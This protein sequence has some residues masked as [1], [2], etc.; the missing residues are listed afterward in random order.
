MARSGCCGGGC[1]CVVMEGAH[2]TVEGSGAP[3]DPFIISADLDLEVVDNS[4]F[5]LTLVGDGSPA[6]PYQLTVAFA[7]TAS[8][9]AFPDWSDTAPTN[10]QVPIWNNGTGMWTPGAQTTASAGSVSHNT[11]LS[12]DGSVGSPLAVV[13]DPARGT[14]TGASGIGL[15]DASINSTVR[16]FANATARAAASP[17]PALNAIS[18]LDSSPGNYDT[19]DGTAWV[20]LEAGVVPLALGP[21][22]LQISGPYTDGR[23]QIV[24]K[25]ETVTTAADGSWPALVAAE[26]VG[27]SGVLTCMITP[28]GPTPFIPMVSGAIPGQVTAAAYAP[29]SGEAYAGVSLTYQLVAV[30][31]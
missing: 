17:A 10:G 12:G 2:V 28:V 11:S 21:E 7:A 30:V 4:T 15:T 1:S 16:R 14:Q 20:P 24:T 27:A 8:V 29:G 22:L 6:S 3:T 13:H 26:L 25:I 23:V 18:V 19:W 9:K 5:N 31:Y